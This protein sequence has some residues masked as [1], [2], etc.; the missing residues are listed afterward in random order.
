M[1][2]DNSWEIVTDP[3]DDMPT[4]PRAIPMWSETYLWCAFDPVR[5]I[6][7]YMH[8]GTTFFDS[9]VWRS[10][11]AVS[12]P[13]GRV[14]IA[15]HYGR[16]AKP[17]SSGCEALGATWVE[18]L[19]RWTVRLDGA[20]RL[21]TR[22]E[23]R[24]SLATDGVPGGAVIELEFTAHSDLLNHRSV[25]WGNLHHNQH[26]RVRGTL[27]VSGEELEFEG[28]GYRDHSRGPRDLS[29]Y[30][31]SDFCWAEFPSGKTFVAAD[32]FFQTSAYDKKYCLVWEDG[33]FRDAEIVS[34]PSLTA[35]ATDPAS[36]MISLD[37][38]AGPVEIPGEIMGAVN[39]T[40]KLPGTELCLGTERSTISPKDMVVIDATTRYTWGD[41]VG[42]GLC[43]WITPI[44]VPRPGK[45][46]IPPLVEIPMFRW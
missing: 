36:V 24:T 21:V 16:A 18:P 12:L 27:N 43:E 26:C 45:S 20:C 41:E 4:E 19:K 5:N 2:T 6:G 32:I 23:N 29:E 42:F 25:H 1:T 8:Q 35:A 46:P 9:T 15:K 17:R 30:V 14:L 34:M 22:E 37:V 3:N 28:P 11:I 13:D 40:H 44:T 7:V 38:G 10:T 31:G 33:A 39:F